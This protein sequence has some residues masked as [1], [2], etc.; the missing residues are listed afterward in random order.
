VNPFPRLV[1][2]AVLDG[3]GMK[4]LRIASLE[5]RGHNRERERSCSRSRLVAARWRSDV[6]GSVG[7]SSK[8]PVRIAAE[9]LRGS[10]WHSEQ[11]EANKKQ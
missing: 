2:V 9:R 7:R 6:P 1:R 5:Q 4:G 8:Q 10:A 11:A 3:S